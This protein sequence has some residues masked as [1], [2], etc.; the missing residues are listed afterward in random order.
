MKFGSRP[1]ILGVMGAVTLWLT[2][3]AL[4]SGQAVQQPRPQV[5]EDVFKNVQIL[6][7]IP[8]DEFMDTMGMFAASL[9]FNCVD[10]HTLQSVG[11][12]DH[13]ADDTPL[14]VTTRKMMLMVN[15]INKDNFSGVRS[16]TCYTC[17]RSDLRPKIVPNL[18]AQYAAY[19]DDPNEPTL[20]PASTG[21]T[22]DQ[23]F[24]KY[25]Q[26]SG[27]AQR[28]AALTSFT[29]KGT[30]IGFETEQTK[31]PVDVYAKAPNQR[32][33]VVHTALGDSTRTY[34]GRSAWIASPDRP[35]GLLTLTGGNLEGARI[36]AS[37]QLPSQLRQTFS[38][39]RVGATTIDDKEVQVL[40]GTNPRQPPVNF[41]F[42]QS[43]LLI[44]ILRYV[45]T[46]VGRVPTQQDYGDYRD[47]AG[48]KL[49]FHWVVTWTDGQ[50]TTDLTEIRPNA[51]IEAARFARPAP[52]R[53]KQ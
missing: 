20:L 42:D 12:W 47:V 2:G 36:D 22:V 28:V 3:V 41:Y 31:V 53:P 7:G 33:I 19:M 40:Q 32:A 21:P 37:V 15:A 38:N 43:G 24:N 35:V 52:I 27:G 6:K 4:A 17:H 39:W 46:A 23:V 1:T 50:A 11:S 13:F 10:C 29:G 18:A 45:D 25:I 8:V 26:A 14:K 44:R 51:A 30:F 48:V 5:S 34:D 49:P 16:V 9:S